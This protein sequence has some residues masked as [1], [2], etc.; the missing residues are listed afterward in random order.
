M[1][2]PMWLKKLIARILRHD[3]VREF[4]DKKIEGVIEDK[5]GQKIDV[6]TEKVFD[7]IADNLE[8]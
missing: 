8:E 1:K 3:E 2:C 5:T 4:V 6:P 7:K